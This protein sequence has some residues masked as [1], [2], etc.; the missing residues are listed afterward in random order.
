[1]IG[2]IQFLKCLHLLNDVSP[3]HSTVTKKTYKIHQNSNNQAAKE[4]TTK[5]SLY[6]TPEGESSHRRPEKRC[7]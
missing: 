6:V 1:M 4:Q 7:N 2:Q 5:R 3:C